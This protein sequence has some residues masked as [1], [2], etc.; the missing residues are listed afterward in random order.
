[1]D[2]L[3]TDRE[4]SLMSKRRHLGSMRLGTGERAELE[5]TDYTNTKVKHKEQTERKTNAMKNKQNRKTLI[6]TL[7]VALK[8]QI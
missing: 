6:L 1:M 4:T 2:Q 8:A 3:K 7:Y 5:L